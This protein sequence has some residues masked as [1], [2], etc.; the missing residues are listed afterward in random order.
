MNRMYESAN[1]D[2]LYFN[3]LRFPEPVSSKLL[4]RPGDL[5]KIR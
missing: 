1:I 3:E 2:V 4:L 5:K